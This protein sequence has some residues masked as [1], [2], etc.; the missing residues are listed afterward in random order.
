MADPRELIES[1]FATVRIDCSSCGVEGAI[2]DVEFVVRSPGEHPYG[3][4]FDLPE[5]WTINAPEDGA[6]CGVG[7]TCAECNGSAPKK[8]KRARR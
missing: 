1:S 8:R 7:L 3:H 5:G 4:R 6:L 2:D